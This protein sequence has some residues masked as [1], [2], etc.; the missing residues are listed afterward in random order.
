MPITELS[1]S[2]A[3]VVVSVDHNLGEQPFASVSA[4]L[5]RA[6]FLKSEGVVD[7][8]REFLY[9]LREGETVGLSNEVDHIS[10]LGA[11]EAIPE[12]LVGV[13]LEGGTLLVV[14]GAQPF[15]SGGTCG[16]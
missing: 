3:V 8:I 1:E 13:D 7:A 11:P 5:L 2:L 15:E 6:I 4:G 16:A 12:P 14:E 9:R 10:T